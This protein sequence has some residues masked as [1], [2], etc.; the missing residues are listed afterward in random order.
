M[1]IEIINETSRFDLTEEQC[2]RYP[3]G[4]L[5]KCQSGDVFITARRYD[6][7]TSLLALDSDPDPED[8]SH[9]RKLLMLSRGGTGIN[10]VQTDWSPKGYK[11]FQLI[12]KVTKITLTVSQ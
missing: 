7:K 3:S 2:C 12:G 1:D 6:M 11:L 10:W 5:F 4:T 9:P 8:T